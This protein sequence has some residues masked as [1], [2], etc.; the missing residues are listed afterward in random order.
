MKKKVELGRKTGAKGI[1]SEGIVSNGLVFCSGQVHMT[2]DGKMVEGSVK[3]KMEVIMA[4][5][6]EVL[7][8]A[9]SSL[10]K[11]VNVTIYVTDMSQMGELNEVYPSYFKGDLPARAAIGVK[12]L[13]LGATIEISLIAEA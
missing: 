7:E 5:I 6:S 8:A 13:P 10:E 11:A 4:N 2:S 3:E 1:L 12:E 9:G